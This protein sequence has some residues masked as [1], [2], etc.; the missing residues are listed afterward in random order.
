MQQEIPVWQQTR[1]QFQA[2]LGV[3]RPY[4]AEIHPGVQYARLSKR[5]RKAYDEKRAA[6]W[7]ASMQ[8]AQDY[9]KAVVEAY[10][11]G[12]FTREDACKEAWSI[13]LSHLV[14]KEKEAKQA[15]FEAR[16]A[17]NPI[18]DAAEVG[19]RCYDLMTRRYG[20]ITKMWKVSAQVR[21]DDGNEYKV[22]IGQL[23][24]RSYNDVK[25]DL[26]APPAPPMTPVATAPDP[27]EAQ[28]I[29]EALDAVEVGEPGD[30]IDVCRRIV[31]NHGAEQHEGVIIDVQT[32]NV[33]VKVFEALN[34]E[35]QGKF[36]GMNDIPK[37][38]AIAWKLVK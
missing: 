24:H 1:G 10:E 31:E 23:W 28:D 8:C 11:A 34:E 26:P 19:M 18:G 37:M 20:V 29:A 35:N 25:E 16:Y 21:F 17:E 32:A 15:A 4:I 12:E 14:A 9:Q 38:A 33:I 6:E 5:A 27:E 36:R 30:P 22:R 13:V 3:P 2:Q 7:D